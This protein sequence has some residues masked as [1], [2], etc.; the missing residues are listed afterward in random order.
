MGLAPNQSR[1]VLKGGA[2]LLTATLPDRASAALVLMLGVGSRF[3]D[4]RIGGISHF[5]EHLFFKGTRRR[6]SAKEIAEA[7]EGVGGV[8]NA[9]TDKEVT[10]Y[11]TRVPADRADL[12][13]DVLFD[14]VSNSQFAPDDVE[15]ERMVI[16]EELKMYLD[17][18]QDYVHSLFERIMWPDHPLGRDIIGTVESVSSTSRDDLLAY[19]Q[20]HYRLPNLV[21]AISGAVQ[22]DQALQLVESR[23]TLPEAPNGSMEFVPAPGPL[24]EPV[25]LLHKKDTEQA[26]I[27]LGTRA[28]S[29]LDPDRYALD[30]LN[31]I[32]GEGMSS[33]LFLEIREKRGLAYDVHSF[34]SKH[35]DAGYFA[36]YMGV[37][38]K[39]AEEAVNAVM[40]ELR[41][42]ASEQV[43]EEELVKVKEFTK[44]RLRLGL[45]GTN[46]LATWLCQQELLTG[47]VKT[48]EEVVQLFEAVT[49][50]ELQRVAQR[51]LSQPVQLAV[52]G[53]FPSDGPFRSAIGA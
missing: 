19:L 30:L 9:S 28:L 17:Q 43:P 34:S 52:I 41:K 18:P 31:T 25:V 16:L 40:E 13:A 26:H 49:L 27:C 2:K 38:P 5:I 51:V 7:I 12:A 20:G 42:V 53:P 3:E 4:D 32:L 10:V 39:K 44:G 1:H 21:M 36:V 15:R 11:W 33:R 29:Y 35:S 47:R 8:I 23:L 6:P 45:E 14:I 46:S 50:E 48:V 24:T 37:D 22:P